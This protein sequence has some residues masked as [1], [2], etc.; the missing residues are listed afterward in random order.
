VGKSCLLLRFCDDAFTPSFITTIGI[1][2]KVKTCEVNGQMVKVQ[3]WDTAGQERFR[4]ITT[5]YYRGAHGVL[6]VYDITDRKT[7]EDIGTWAD[8]VAAFAP[9]NA[10]RILVGNKVDCAESRQVSRE[11]GEERAAH[12]GMRFVET[13]AKSS[14]GVEDAFITLTR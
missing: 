2:F 1:D 11:E 13:S 3:V 5:S 14:A 4:T 7:F 8:T 6:V 10:Q 12:L 9:Q